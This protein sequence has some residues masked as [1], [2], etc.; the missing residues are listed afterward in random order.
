MLSFYVRLHRFQDIPWNVIKISRISFHQANI[1]QEKSEMEICQEAFGDGKGSS[2][3]CD[4]VAFERRLNCSFDGTSKL[5][6]NLSSAEL[7]SHFCLA[8][9]RSS[10]YYAKFSCSLVISEHQPISK[11]IATLKR[12]EKWDGKTG[13]AAGIK[14]RKD[15]KWKRQGMNFIL[16]AISVSQFSRSSRLKN[17]FFKQNLCFL[18]CLKIPQLSPSWQLKLLRFS[19]RAAPALADSMR[20]TWTAR[21]SSV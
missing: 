6:R 7:M 10:F 12:A 9:K 19:L 18:N 3:K 8:A 16:H 5:W 11:F 2:L 14:R 21:S 13:Y 4:S 17:S 1:Q 20:C 15:D